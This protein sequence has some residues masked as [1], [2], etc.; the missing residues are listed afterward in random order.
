MDVRIIS[1]IKEAHTKYILDFKHPSSHIVFV[2]DTCTI[3][4]TLIHND[5]TY[6]PIP[7]TFQTLIRNYVLKHIYNFLVET[8]NEMF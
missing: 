7:F 3:Y 4:F 2:F 5:L 6:D 1:S 8:Y